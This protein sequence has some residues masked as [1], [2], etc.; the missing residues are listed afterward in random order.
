MCDRNDNH[1]SRREPE[2]PKRE[3]SNDGTLPFASIV[4]SENSDHP[5]NTSKDSAVN[6][7]R[8]SVAYSER[9]ALCVILLSLAVGHLIL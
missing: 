6:H 5:F 3:L 1:L 8:S 2:R 7:D 9:L 4:L